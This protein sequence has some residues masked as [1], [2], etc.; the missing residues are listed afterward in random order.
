M[1]DKEIYCDANVIYKAISRTIKSSRRNKRVT[2]LYQVNQLLYTAKLQKAMRDETYK[3]SKGHKFTLRERGKTRLIT[4]NIMVDKVVNHIICDEVLTPR[5][6]KYLIHDNSASQKNKGVSFHRRRFEER[7]RRAKNGY[8]LLGDFAGYYANISHAKAYETLAKFL[9]GYDFT[10]SLIK[11][12]METFGGD[13]GIDIGTQISQNIGLI[14]AYRFD[15]YARIVAGIK[16]YGRYT[17]DFYAISSSREELKSLL[18]GL[19]TIAAEA[20]IIINERKTRIIKL[21]SFFRYLQHGYSMKGKLIRKINPKTVTRERRKIKAYQRALNDDV[22]EE[23]FKGW[24][25][26]NYRRMSHIQIYNISKLIRRS[27]T[28]QKHSR[29]RY[30]MDHRL[31]S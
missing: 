17:D 9:A 10:L 8:V 11:M 20:G 5:L 2:Q 7:L 25:C 1:M 16:G 31:A 3:P 26:S 19:K 28:W 18:D 15:N 22:I 24:I 29:L 14:F 21:S 13:K 12:I 4:N 27:G 6:A 30:L 23:F